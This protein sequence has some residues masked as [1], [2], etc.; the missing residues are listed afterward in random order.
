ME[1]AEAVRYLSGIIPAGDEKAK[2]ALKAIELAAIETGFQRAGLSVPRD[3]YG[4]ETDMARVGKVM[5]YAMAFGNLKE[6]SRAYREIAYNMVD[7]DRE[8]SKFNGIVYLKG[9]TEEHI[10]Q[11]TALQ[12]K[13]RADLDLFAQS[14]VDGREFEP[15]YIDGYLKLTKGELEALQSQYDTEHLR[16]E[17]LEGESGLATIALVAKT[18]EIEALSHEVSEQKKKIQFYEERSGRGNA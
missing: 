13:I 3:F 5:E 16:A 2:E 10:W 12:Q 15:G 6:I 1:A 14:V 18:R 9:Y 11:A 17:R 4:T 8:G 7:W